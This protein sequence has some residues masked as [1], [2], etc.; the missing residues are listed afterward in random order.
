MRTKEFRKLDEL[1][2]KAILLGVIAKRTEGKL[3]KVE[4]ETIVNNIDVSKQYTIQVISD[5]K[6]FANLITLSNHK[7]QHSWAGGEENIT[8]GQI[9]LGEGLEFGENY[10]YSYSENGDQTED[11]QEYKAPDFKVCRKYVVYINE[12]SFS[13]FNNNNYENDRDSIVIYIP[14]NQS[15]KIDPV[16]RF[17][18]DNFNI[19]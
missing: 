2:K 19:E 7:F 1:E 9:L 5:I 11:S 18:L 4:L 3:S 15:F 12:Y 13:N 14:E 6:Q 17:I 8:T 16:V 10:S